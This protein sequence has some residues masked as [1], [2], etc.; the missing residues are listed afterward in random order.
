MRFSTVLRA[1]FVGALFFSPAMAD[2]V[3]KVHEEALRVLREHSG[4]AP[5]APQS[6]LRP[7]A[8]PGA[9]AAAAPI[10]RPSIEE[11]RQ[12]EAEVARA[13]AERERRLTEEARQQMAERALAQEQKRLDFEA[14]LKE[15]E[16]LRQQQRD[17][18]ET[19]VRG[20]GQAMPV[21]GGGA[22][23]NVQDVHAKALKALYADPGTGSQPGGAAVTPE[24][25]TRSAMPR[26]DEVAPVVFG[27]SG[28]NAE[29]H[30]KALEVL[31]RQTSGMGSATEPVT[32]TQEELRERARQALEQ[33][34]AEMRRATAGAQA[35]GAPAVS[36]N[37]EYSKE[38]ERRA[39]EILRENRGA[40]AV[41]APAQPAT[42]SATSFQ[43]AQATAVPP[44]ASEIHEK[45]LQALRQQEA[46]APATSPLVSPAL[47]Q[48]TREILQRQDREIAR[49]LASP[50][51]EPTPSR[52]LNPDAE[53]RAREIL[54][55][56]QQALS[57]AAP[58]EVAVPS[59]TPAPAAP[60]ATT[61]APATSSD[62]SRDLEERARQIIRERAQETTAVPAEPSVSQPAATGAVPEARPS[63]AEV[64]QQ[65]LDALNQAR[66][67]NA[68]PSA[69]AGVKTKRDRIRELTDLYREDKMTPAE[70]HQR[71]A[72]ILAEPN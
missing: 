43:P 39:L 4:Q 25:S 64:H 42:E 5:P 38:L 61:A 13:R 18:D 44:A 1:S 28:D 33:Q 27:S 10:R 36:D 56:Q 66:Q 16:I 8:V 40:A 19:V 48:G 37:T 58:P 26:E 34:Q 32:E 7:A 20:A 52:G 23:G 9:P 49:Q 6:T 55:Q 15:R 54:R 22:T 53:A 29:T 24:T 69:P 57:P 67:N 21:A 2:E 17:Q 51:F 47:D 35:E 72:Q 68:S 31:R 62:Y 70:Y 30:A 3:E 63:V 14:F 65:A 46:S 59:V 60:P 50:R 11:S 12:A 71:R 45:A 41:P